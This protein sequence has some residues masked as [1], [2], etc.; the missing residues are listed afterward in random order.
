[1]PHLENDVSIFFGDYLSLIQTQRK[2]GGQIPF[3]LK[4]EFGTIG[5]FSLIMFRAST[6]A[7]KKILL[8]G[9]DA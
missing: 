7:S 1:V 4:R 8:S 6:G 5:V 9:M 2:A 3:D